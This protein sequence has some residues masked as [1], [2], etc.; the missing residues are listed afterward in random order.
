MGAVPRVEFLV[1]RKVSGFPQGFWQSS[2]WHPVAIPPTL[3]DPSQID[4]HHQGVSQGNG[5][6]GCSW[7]PV[8]A[9]FRREDRR[10]SGVPSVTVPVSPRHRLGDEADDRWTERR[11]PVDPL[12]SAGWPWL[13]WWSRSALPQSTIDAEQDYKPSLPCLPSRPPDPP[14]QDQDPENRHL[15]QRSGEVG[16]QQ[17]GRG[18]DFHL[19]WEHYQPAGR[20]RCRR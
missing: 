9:S 7:R 16:R 19:P 17:P 14:Q 15:Q 6:S 3:W 5:L 12:D 1:V 4:T 18:W 10:S 8:D 2:S 13:S 11:H 20:N